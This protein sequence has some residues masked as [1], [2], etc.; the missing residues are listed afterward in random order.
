MSKLIDLKAELAEAQDNVQLY[1]HIK[2]STI[3]AMQEN[4]DINPEFILNQLCED[5][6]M[7]RDDFNLIGSVDR[8]MMFDILGKFKKTGK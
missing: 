4:P 7:T 3:Q 1:A 8:Q 2:N 6:E 5:N